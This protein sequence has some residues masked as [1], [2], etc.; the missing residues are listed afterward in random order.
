VT[1]NKRHVELTDKCVIV[2][3]EHMIGTLDT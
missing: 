1:L 3:R 2:T